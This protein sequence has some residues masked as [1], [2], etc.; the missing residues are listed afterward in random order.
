[1]IRLLDDALLASRTG[2]GGLALELIDM[3]EL[4][5]AETEDRRAHDAVVGYARPA[6]P[7]G[8]LAVLGDRLALR[9]VVANLLDNAIR[10]GRGD[11]RS[12]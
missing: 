12:C 5:R 10:R 3:D 2:S 7:C 11:Q 8:E 1:M 6:R 9:R 4:V